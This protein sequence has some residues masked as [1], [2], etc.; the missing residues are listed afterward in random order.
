MVFGR[1]VRALD[2]LSLAVEPGII[3]GLL[4]PSA[5]GQTT[6]IRVLATRLPPDAGSAR[7]AGF[8]VRRQAGEMRDR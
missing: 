7:V 5:A 2:R 1:Q 6:L 4:G 8:D 3:Y